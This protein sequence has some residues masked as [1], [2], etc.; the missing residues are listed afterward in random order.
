M[1]MT[2]QMKSKLSGQTH[3]IFLPIEPFEY[4][5]WLIAEPQPLIQDAFPQL[6]DDEREFIKTGITPAEWDEA[7]G[8]EEEEYNPGNELPWEACIAAENAEIAAVIAEANG[9]GDPDQI[10]F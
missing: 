7:F 4:I 2:L 8:E 1:S 3:E 10:P 9:E 5:K 6:S